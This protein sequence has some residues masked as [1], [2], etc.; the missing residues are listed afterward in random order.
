MVAVAN[1]A[2][3]R[4]D[5]DHVNDDSCD[6]SCDCDCANC[7]YVNDE[8]AIALVVQQVLIVLVAELV[9]KKT[10]L[11]NGDKKNCCYL[12]CSMIGDCGDDACCTK[13]DVHLG[14]FEI[15]FSFLQIAFS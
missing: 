9:A 6:E 5:Y 7:G 10:N 14:A 2:M 4:A 12:V 15:P 1:V 13:S 3:D 11:T 8:Q